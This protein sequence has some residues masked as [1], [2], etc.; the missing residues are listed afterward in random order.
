MWKRSGKKLT[1]RDVTTAFAELI[2]TSGARDKL[3]HFHSRIDR[4]YEPPRRAAA[5]SLLAQLSV[6][7]NGLSRTALL[8][9]STP[10]AF[11][12]TVLE[13]ESKLLGPAK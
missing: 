5:Y 11:I 12:A 7:P 6:S 13:L 1:V 9:A 4:Y 2:V 3:Q 10:E 8:A